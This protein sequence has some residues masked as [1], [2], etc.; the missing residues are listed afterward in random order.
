MHKS[1]AIGVEARIAAKEAIDAGKTVAVMAREIKY[2]T[3]IP[4]TFS[5]QVQREVVVN[6]KNVLAIQSLRATNPRSLKCHAGKAIEQSGNESIS[7]KRVIFA[8]RM[9]SGDLSTRTATGSEEEGVETVVEVV[10]MVAVDS[11]LFPMPKR[12]AVVA[13][14]TAAEAPAITAMVSFDMTGEGGGIQRRGADAWWAPLIS[15]A[16]WDRAS[17]EV[18]I[19]VRSLNARKARPCSQ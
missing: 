6:I 3:P 13:A 12:A 4:K 14:P 10:A 17:C 15:A 9:K 1:I 16:T 19:H 18:V 7:N 11:F 8:N 5:T 2:S